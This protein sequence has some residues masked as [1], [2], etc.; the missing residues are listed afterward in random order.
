MHAE[1]CGCIC[2]YTTQAWIVQPTRNNKIPTRRRSMYFLI[3]FWGGGQR[4]RLDCLRNRSVYSGI[5]PQFRR[6][7][8]LHMGI[9]NP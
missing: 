4:N 1:A 6:R 7:G 9:A 2:M 3:I 8:H 5:T